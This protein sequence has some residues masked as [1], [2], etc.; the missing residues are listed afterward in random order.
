MTATTT[1]RGQ[2]LT[3]REESRILGELRPNKDLASSPC[4]IDHPQMPSNSPSHDATI[5]DQFTQQAARFA[6][7]PEL[8]ND[9]VL[10]LLTEAARPRLTDRMLD[11]ACG[12]GSVVAAFAPL[13][14]H[15][16]GVDATPAMLAEARKLAAA[17]N[18]RNVGWRNGSAYAL[19]YRDSSFDIV[20]TRFAF[21][22]LEEP[23]A[24]FAEMVRVARPDA[25]IVLCDA[26]ASDDPA[27]ALAFNE[28]DRWRDPSTVEYRT[29]GYLQNLFCDAGLPSPSLSRFQVRYLAHEFVARAFPARDDRAGLLQLIERSVDGDLLGMNAQR[30]PEGVDIAFQCVVLV[31][32]KV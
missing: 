9:A 19:P 3:S 1:S 23:P 22:H 12:P 6:A 5:T 13:V 7:A 14:Q 29:L 30:S 32:E 18:L 2:S 28:M 24:A 4:W 15:A 26:V 27:K 8:H 25:R 10:A 31:A 20:A 17:K 11:V 16:E 21:H